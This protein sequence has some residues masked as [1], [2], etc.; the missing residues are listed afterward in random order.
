MD[1]TKCQNGKSDLHLHLDGSLPYGILP[2][3]YE[4]SG[5]DYEGDASG[6]IKNKFTVPEGCTSLEEYLKCFDLP[7]RLLQSKECLEA[8]TSALIKELYS[9]NTF[10]TEIRFAPQFHRRKGLSLEDVVEAAIQGMNTGLRE[11]P[12]MT[13]SLILCMM[14]GATKEENNA[15][16][17]VAKK[18][19]GRGVGAVDR[20]GAE[21]MRD[22]NLDRDLFAKASK[23]DIPFTIH[24]GECGSFEN[25]RTAIEFGAKR[26]GHGVA[27]YQDPGTIDLLVKKQIPIEVCVISNL[28]TIATPVDEVHPIKKLLDAGVAVTINT[29]NRTVSGTTLD[30]EYEYIMKNCGFNEA[31]IV[32]CQE[33]ARKAFF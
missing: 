11:C 2:K 5:L 17:D 6:G 13:A 3:L 27:A 26:I 23:L 30:R 14:I 28:Q 15:V 18:Y 33:N 1:L 24:A 16:L 19:I 22:L 32:K 10:H 8:A 20:A 4:L 29:D 7:I 9:E 31:D 12:D 25:I 21:R